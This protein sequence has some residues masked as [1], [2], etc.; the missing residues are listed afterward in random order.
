M[1]GLPRNLTLSKK[2][3][4]VALKDIAAPRVSSQVFICER[5]GQWHGSV[6]AAGH[7]APVVRRMPAQSMEMASLAWASIIRKPAIR[8]HPGQRA[9]Q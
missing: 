6:H 5:F 8:C 2:P 3:D 9:A 1:T 4:L 7:A